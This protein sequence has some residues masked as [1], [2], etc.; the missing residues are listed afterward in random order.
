MNELM[1]SVPLY[2]LGVGRTQ[3]SVT[4]IALV[5]VIVLVTVAAVVIVSVSVLK[6]LLSDNLA[7]F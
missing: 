7:I 6:I 2:A 5:G 4:V 1:T 3:V